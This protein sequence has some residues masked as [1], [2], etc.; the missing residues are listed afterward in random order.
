[1]TVRAGVRARPGGGVRSARRHLVPGFD[2]ALVFDE[3]RTRPA[4]LDGEAA[5][6]ARSGR[7]GRVRGPAAR[8]SDRPAGRSTGNARGSPG[9]GTGGGGRTG[10][11]GRPWADG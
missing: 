6:S 7:A 5:L 10:D 1:M 9:R 11:A 4:T 3:L 2:W 8:A